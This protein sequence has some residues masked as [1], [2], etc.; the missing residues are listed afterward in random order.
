M[1]ETHSPAAPRRSLYLDDLSV[2]D[3]FISGE[4]ALDAAQIVA[5][6]AQFDPQ[7]FHTDPDA[8]E[9]TFFRGLAASGWHTAALTMKLL[10][11][12]GLPLADGVIGS[13][14]ELQWPQ[15]TRP[16]DVLHVEAE[17]LEIVPSRS[18]PGRAMVQ[19]RCE[20]KNQ[21]GEVLQRFTPK[22]VVVGQSV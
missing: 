13:G 17:I 20:T 5:F 22:L 19:A 18:K 1:A 6:A 15:P 10:V 11:E 4:H 2:G 9:A 8:A 7:P 21:R 12:S 16:D 3:R 14:G